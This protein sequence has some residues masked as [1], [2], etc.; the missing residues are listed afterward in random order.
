MLCEVDYYLELFFESP[1]AEIY[2]EGLCCLQKVLHIIEK[3]VESP[4]TNYQVVSLQRLAATILQNTAFKLHD[5]YT[6]TKFGCVS[7]MLYIA[8][9]YD[10]QIHRNCIC[11]RD[12]K[13]LIGTISDV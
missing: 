9:Y 11:Y 2:P 7:D 8:M 1:A 5:M 10:I 13:G 3:L 12:Y 4:L 6:N